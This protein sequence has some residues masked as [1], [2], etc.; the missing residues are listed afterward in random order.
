[1]FYKFQL[2]T[3]KL[4]KVINKS[5]EKYNFRFFNKKVNK[6][7]IPSKFYFD[8]Y[9]YF[10]IIKNLPDRKSK[11]YEEDIIIDGLPEKDLKKIKFIL[12]NNTSGE[13]IKNKLIVE[14]NNEKYFK[15]KTIKKKV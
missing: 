1:M 8:R 3:K 10:N 12:S 7:I 6:I 9:Y 11:Y 15:E 14:K 13:E 5:F 2:Q 4:Q